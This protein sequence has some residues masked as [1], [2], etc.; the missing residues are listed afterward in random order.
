MQ[1]LCVSLSEMFMVV[2]ACIRPSCCLS[3]AIPD[4][5]V[6]SGCEFHDLLQIE[7]SLET[8]KL[9]AAKIHGHYRGGKY[10]KIVNDECGAGREPSDNW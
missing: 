6:K 7:L 1:K 8:L 9:A 3:K 4:Q 10:L 5:Y 2:C